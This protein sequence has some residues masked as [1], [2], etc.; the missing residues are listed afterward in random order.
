MQN[1]CEGAGMGSRSKAETQQ[2]VAHSNCPAV[3]WPRRIC[4]SMSQQLCEL[5]AEGGGL[6][7]RHRAK[8][9]CPCGTDCQSHAAESRY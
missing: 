7:Q 6:L 3:W 9:M 5:L 1:L 4:G 8:P 2:E